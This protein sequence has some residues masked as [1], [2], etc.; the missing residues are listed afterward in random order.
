MRPANGCEGKPASLFCSRKGLG[1]EGYLRRPDRP[2]GHRTYMSDA[3][4]QSSTVLLCRRLILW[5]LGIGAALSIQHLPVDLG[6]GVCGPW[7]CGPS[8]KT[9]LACHLAWLAFLAPPSRWVTLGSAARRHGVAIA[10][11]FLPLSAMIGMAAYVR[12]V[13]LPDAGEFY[14]DYLWQRVMFV[15]VTEVRVPILAALAIGVWCQFVGHGN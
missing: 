10:L 2:N 6:H 14:A 11:I 15:I 13:W 8:T 12:W 3:L 5:A 9:L 7:G 1:R 4:I